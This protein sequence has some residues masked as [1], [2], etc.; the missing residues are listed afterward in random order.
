MASTTLLTDM[1]TAISTGPSAASTA[2]AIAAAGPII[3][4]PGG[5]KTV[6]L[7]LQEAKVLL[8]QIITSDIDSGDGIKTGLQG[9]LDS[10]S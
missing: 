9:V 10:L 3:D 6:Q 2:K 1:A 7:K 8:S 5:L 4:L